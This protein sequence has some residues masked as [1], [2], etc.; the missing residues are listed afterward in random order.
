[1]R[2]DELRFSTLKNMAKSPAHVRAAHEA[3]FTSSRAMNFGTLVHALILGGD[4]VVYEGERRGK[5]WDAFKEA[6]DGRF[7]VTSKERD[8][9]EE[10]AASVLLHPVA[11]PL[12]QGDHERAWTATMYGRK[13]KGRMDVSGPHTVD[14]KTTFDASPFRFSRQCLSMAYHA[15]LRWYQD[16]R[17]AMGENP[18]DAYIIGVETKVPYPV[19][20]LKVT[21]RALEEG[22]K[23]TRLWLERLKQCEEA[24][25]WPGYVQSAID[26]DIAEDDHGLIIGDDEEEEAAQ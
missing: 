3:G 26:L 16:A 10:C 20:V 23:L 8:A 7:I 6:H 18:G 2:L 5:A 1:M 12:L 11:A 24:D 19:T 22:A 9:A 15:Q 14:V 21:P 13:C 4:V 25:E 17:R